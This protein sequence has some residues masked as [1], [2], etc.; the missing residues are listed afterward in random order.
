MELFAILCLHY[1]KGDDDS[2]L[3]IVAVGGVADFICH[4]NPK[5]KTQV[6]RFMR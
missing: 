1:W 6:T 4:K 3:C 2:I 5:G